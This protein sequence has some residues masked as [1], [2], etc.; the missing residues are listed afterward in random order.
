MPLEISPEIDHCAGDPCGDH[1]VCYN[2]TD[3]WICKCTSGFTGDNCTIG[4]KESKI[5]NKKIFQKDKNPTFL[6]YIKDIDFCFYFRHHLA[7]EIS[8]EIDY[9]AGDPCRD[10]GTPESGFFSLANL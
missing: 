9:C 10:E 4:E 3:G 6:V 5:K 2:T 1:G 7:L 8:P